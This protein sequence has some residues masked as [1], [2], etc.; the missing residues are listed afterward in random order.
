MRIVYLKGKAIGVSGI[1]LR[2]L[3]YYS[4]SNNKVVEIAPERLFHQDIWYPAGGY[5]KS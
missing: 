5:S 2:H 4:S 3:F 1:I